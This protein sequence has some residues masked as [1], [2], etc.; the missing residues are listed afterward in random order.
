MGIPTFIKKY[1]LI[2][3]RIIKINQLAVGALVLI[4][5]S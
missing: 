3:N 5:T 1:K 4:G 2:F